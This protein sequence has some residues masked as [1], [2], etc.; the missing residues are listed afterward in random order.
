VFNDRP[1]ADWIQISPVGNQRAIN[2][3]LVR[4]GASMMS[5]IA[6]IVS[7]RAEAPVLLTQL[8]SSS[9]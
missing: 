9:R 4:R 7:N 2:L 1:N 6:S 5:G 8:H 3:I